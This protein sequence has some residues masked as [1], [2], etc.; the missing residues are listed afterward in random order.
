MIA[1]KPLFEIFILQDLSIRSYKT[2]QDTLGSIRNFWE[3]GGPVEVVIHNPHSIPVFKSMKKKAWDQSCLL[4]YLIF[5]VS[6]MSTFPPMSYASFL[7]NVLDICQNFTTFTIAL[8]VTKHMFKNNQPKH[9]PPPPLHPPIFHACNNKSIP[10]TLYLLS[11]MS[12]LFCCCTFIKFSLCKI[13][14]PPPPLLQ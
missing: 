1:S 11:I 9:P 8:Y 10:S 6:L 13:S 5:S 7:F 14:T 4:L 3:V 12:S 2:W